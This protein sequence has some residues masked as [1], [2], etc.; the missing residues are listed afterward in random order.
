MCLK[1]QKKIFNTYYV[2][3]LATFTSY[4]FSTKTSY[5]MSYSSYLFIAKRSVSVQ[6]LERA[7]IG[8]ALSS[9]RNALPLPDQ[10]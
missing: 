1:K 10:K 2:Y 4:H 6:G 5:G 7:A 3:K 8:V 9:H